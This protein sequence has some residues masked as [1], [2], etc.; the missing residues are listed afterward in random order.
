[1][2]LGAV[3]DQIIKGEELTREQAEELMTLL[4]NGEATHAQAGGI[5]IGLRA[6]GCTSREL[7]AFGKILRQHVV[8][9]SHCYDDLVDVVGT[10][11]G[12]PSFNISTGA[13][14]VAAAAG[15]RVAKHGNRAVTS[16]CGSADV[17]E[18]LGVNLYAD[19]EHL[20]TV[21]ESCGIVFML[22]PS[23]HP[24]LRHISAPRR[25]LGIR[26]VFNVLGPIVNPAGVIRQ[27]VGVYDRSLSRAAAEALLELGAT[28]T[29]VVHSDDGMD[30]ISPVARTHYVK[31]W[32]GAV[33]EG[34]FEPEDFGLSGVPEDV[35]TPDKTV[36]G[37]AAIL[38]EALGRA[39]SPRSQALIPSAATALWLAAKAEDLRAGAELAR[40]AIAS[41]AALAKLHELA[42]AS[43]VG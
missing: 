1:M 14:I 42:E 8:P 43:Q 15:A 23:H 26:T 30:E 31:V 12:S 33:E 24:A 28:R 9:V 16:H 3:L 13:C 6:K 29:L 4:V 10:G 17:L 40:K 11:G 25:E 21:L 5:L 35:A 41:G 7:A 38:R 37:N 20:R 18:A 32:G 39:D 2:N 34:H 36:D 22:A 27:V 19:P